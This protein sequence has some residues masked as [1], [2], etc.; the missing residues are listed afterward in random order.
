MIYL[1]YPGL[2]YTHNEGKAKE[3]TVMRQMIEKKSLFA[4]LWFKQ[5]YVTSVLIKAITSQWVHMLIYEPAYVLKTQATTG[6]LLNE[7]NK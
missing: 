5:N 6:I 3:D 4:T 1:K 7:S 2:S